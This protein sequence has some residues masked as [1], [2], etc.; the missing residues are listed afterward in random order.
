MNKHFNDDSIICIANALR[1]FPEHQERLLD[2][3]WRG[4]IESKAWLID[5]LNDVCDNDPAHNIYIFGGWYGV[6][7]TM[8]FD[9]AK[10]PINLI[11]SIDIDPSCE[12]VADQVNKSNEMEKWRFKA[13]TSDMCRWE[14][15]H[16]PTMVINT[17]CEHVDQNTYDLWYE[18]I[19]LN[20]IVVL[21][22]NDF[23]SCKEHV[24]CSNTLAEFVSQS[25]DFQQT[26]YVGENDVV[27][28]NRYM[29]IGMK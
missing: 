19:P 26:F 9:S 5:K 28:Y 20:T 23:F 14:Y 15:D 6:L 3:F 8:L 21:Q 29:L 2:C 11:R 18:K 10:F 7:A 17:S 22:G 16:P 24:R 1:R 12:A 13:F 4:Q 27:E 25:G